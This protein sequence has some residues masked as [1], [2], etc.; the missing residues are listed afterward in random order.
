MIIRNISDVKVVVDTLTEGQPVI[1]P[2]DTVYG[3]CAS[4]VDNEAVNRL[5]TLK[6]RDKV[7]P[8]QL[9][10]PDEWEYLKKYPMSS[11]LKS[12]I[13]KI[14][15]GKVT[16]LFPNSPGLSSELCPYFRGLK[17]LGIRSPVHP[18]WDEIFQYYDFSIAATSANISGQPVFD[19]AEI[20]RVF[21]NT[22]SL[23]CLEDT[24][25]SSESSAVIRFTGSSS[26]E[27]IRKSALLS[28]DIYHKLEQFLSG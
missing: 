9:L 18:L 13:Q 10:V 20:I 3:L 15:R 7:K 27:I 6:E 2:T 11:G 19:E 23:I 12:L 5:F 24:P 14:P 16:W 17:Y 22:V 28:D 26:V 8:L 1:V 4:A 21:G 25:F